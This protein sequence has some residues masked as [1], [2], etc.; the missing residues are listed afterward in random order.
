M[1]G[2]ESFGQKRQTSL[3]ETVTLVAKERIS[4]ANTDNTKQI[5]VFLYWFFWCVNFA[6]L[7]PELCS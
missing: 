4:T 5:C 7:V 6:S 1:V 3:E 2:L